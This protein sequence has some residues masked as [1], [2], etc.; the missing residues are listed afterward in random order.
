MRPHRPDPDS[1]TPETTSPSIP[2]PRT[3]EDTPPSRRKTRSS[4]R[5]LVVRGVRRD[6]P[7]VHKLAQVVAS[8]AEDMVEDDAHERHD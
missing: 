5:N 4:G 7:D 6:P 8:L 3:P 1:A 2:Q